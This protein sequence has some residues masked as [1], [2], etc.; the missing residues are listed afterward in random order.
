MLFQSY[1]LTISINPI[2]IH[3]VLQDNGHGGSNL[4]SSFKDN[5]LFAPYSHSFALLVNTLMTQVTSFSSFREPIIYLPYEQ[6]SGSQQRF[7][8]DVRIKLIE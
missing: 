7:F 2:I 5:S 6:N 3:S 8:A 1:L 4:P